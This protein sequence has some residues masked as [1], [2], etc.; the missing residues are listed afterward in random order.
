MGERIDRVV[1]GVQALFQDLS[2]GVREERVVRYLVTEL[3]KGRDFDDVLNDPYVRNNT[4]ADDRARLLE[5]PETIRKIEDEIAAEF[6]DYR[7]LTGL[8]G[9]DDA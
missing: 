8:P 5:N 9:R 7:R 4:D 2:E 6:E 1:R 3:Q